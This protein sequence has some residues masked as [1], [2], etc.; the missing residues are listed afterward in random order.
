L[1]TPSATLVL[2]AAFHVLVLQT[3]VAFGEDAR[4]SDL[5]VAR[6]AVEEGL[7][8]FAVPVLERLSADRAFGG[9]DEATLL[10][11][12]CRF[13]LRRYDEAARLLDGYENVFVDSEGFFLDAAFY[14]ARTDLER[15]RRAA[16]NPEDEAALLA[17]SRKGFQRVL[18]E[19]GDQDLTA[20]ARFFLGVALYE[21]REYEEALK[22][23]ARAKSLGVPPAEVE[24]LSLHIGHCYLKLRSFERALAAYTF[25]TS[26]FPESALAARGHYGVGEAYYY[27]EDWEDAATAYAASRDAAGRASDSEREAQAR[28]ARGW[29]LSKFG[30]KLER[31]RD[32]EGARKAW[33]EALKE[34]EQL[35]TLPLGIRRE[36]AIFESGELLFRLKRYG[37]AAQRLWQLQD[38]DL[39][40]KHAAPA[41][42]ILGQSRAALAQMQ[43]AAEA[44]RA[45]LEK[46]D[47]SGDLARRIRFGLAEALVELGQPDEARDVLAALTARNESPSVRAEAL[48][49]MGRVMIRAAEVA[50]RGGKNNE[51]IGF[52]GRAYEIF[53]KL[54]GDASAMAELSPEEV[55]YWQA[56]SADARSRLEQSQD[57]ADTW[58]A[59]ATSA[60]RKA[61]GKS[62]W[63]GWAAR[64]LVSEAELH[65]YRG[66]LD[67]AVDAY[68]Q[69]LLH[70]DD[71]EGNDADRADAEMRTRLLLADAELERGNPGAG[72]EALAPLLVEK[73]FASGIAEAS[74]KNA[75]AL[76]REDGKV[77]QARSALEAFLAEH[78]DSTWR[79]D[80][81]VLLGDVKSRQKEY[82]EAVVEYERLLR[83]FPEYAGRDRVEFAAGDA[84]RAAGDVERS[85]EHFRSLFE[86]G[87]SPELRA[88]SRVEEG[89]IAW[90]R[91]QIDDALRL[92]DEALGVAISGHVANTAHELRGMALTSL[93][94]YEDSAAAFLK[95][96]EDEDDSFRA[97][98]TFQHA[99][100]LFAWGRS[101][102]RGDPTAVLRRS[103]EAY[104]DVA[105][106][107]PEADIRER[108]IFAGA[109]ALVELASVEESNGRGDAAAEELDEALSLLQMVQ[110]SNE[111]RA[112]VRIREVQL[113]REA[114]GRGG[115]Q[116]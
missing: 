55:S 93:R 17:R 91:A 113:M 92:A 84:A 64:A 13:R 49:Q 30:E 53:R 68:H 50:V 88:R 96:A 9:R 69:L 8:L 5:A 22:V 26:N 39:Y 10:L 110:E 16:A 86:R 11:A 83:D 31:S 73:R 40:P 21:Q 105:H 104:V 63:G 101:G 99:G 14:L 29:A 44:Y 52:Y 87:G 58:A 75:V 18:D 62:G 37:E 59:W 89:R 57:G 51:A 36:S 4:G 66:N 43:E 60:Y 46:S 19:S 15:A 72:R 65:V 28:Y 45:A 116:P 1:N 74:Y 7:V 107:T 34:F 109:E 24:S 23:F 38:A 115:L 67:G 2:A 33:E 85:L 71:I 80:A 56:I 77:E 20:A 102:E 90:A 41:L 35:S 112:A 54:E 82:A 79:A 81:I 47:A 100:A 61:R 27:L 114:I 95:A 48:R 94:R 103:A 76:A 97:R 32:D 25:F 12:R 42:Y 70:T 108:A 6:S 3:P 98:A 78:P 111:K 106:R